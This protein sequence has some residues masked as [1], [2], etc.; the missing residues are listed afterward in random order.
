MPLLQ[1]QSERRHGYADLLR[2]PQRYRVLWRLW[3]GG[4]TRLL[5]W[6][7]PE[8]VRRYAES[9]RLYDGDSIDVNEMQATKMLGEPHD[10]APWAFVNAK[11]RNG[12]YEFERYWHFFQVWG[13]V[14]YNPRTPADVWRHEFERRYGA[15]GPELMAG[16]H[17][18]SKV[19]P[20]IV[21]AAY[22]YSLFPTTRGWAE[23]QRQGDLP[24][25]ATLEGSDT[26]QFMSP[27]DEARSLLDRTPTSKRRP[28]DTAKWFADTADR[29]L[30]HVSRVDGSRLNGEGAATVADL[31]IL[32]WLA[33]FYAERLPAAVS[34]NLYKDTGSKAELKD[35]IDG[36]RRAIAA[37][38]KVV[39]S[40]S[41]VY[42]NEVAFGAHAVGFPRHWREELDGLRSGVAK[43]SAGL[44]DIAIGVGPTRLGR[45]ADSTPPQVT[46]QP[47]AKAR[48]GA[49]FTVAA[50][51]EDPSGIASLR[52]RYRH[53][54]QVE[55][56]KTADMTPDPKTGLYSA[57]IPGDFIT[58]TW[59]LIYF[60]EAIDKAGNGRNYPDLEKGAPYVIVPVAR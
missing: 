37:W 18:A 34:Y 47:G 2:Y 48:P 35:A 31:K 46:L 29:I 49:P 38:E 8:Y 4:S 42:A 50:R 33:R 20:R 16:L 1:R 5:L 44:G 15:A 23:M 52:L 39:E 11:Y 10:K 53:L 27:K 43:W 30:A 26:E 55:D 32:A 13:R 45:G 7:D 59:D 57:A 22:R 6:A 21:A 40:A 3:S 24:Q 28:E 58:S 9:A 54:T 36:E 19:V 60:I 12:E 17:E 51:A 56:Y 14:S 41:D 25:F